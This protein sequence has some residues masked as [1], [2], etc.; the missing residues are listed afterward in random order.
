MALQD[1]SNLNALHLDVL[2]EIGNIGSGNAAS[3]LSQMLGMPINIEIPEISI[4]D[5]NEA[6]ER[7]GG[8][9]TV[10]AGLLLP[11]SVDL[12]GMI[13]FLF[14][15]DFAKTLL[16]ALMFVEINSFDEI[17]EMGFSAIHE[18]GN[19]A[20][21]AFVNAVAGM[22]GMTIDISPPSSTIDMVGAIMNVPAVYCSNISDRLL[23]MKNKFIC[24]DKH[25]DAHILLLPDIE[26]LER[27]MTKL[28]IEI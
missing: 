22:T 16:K 10:M 20:A 1:Y 18:I 27:L 12:T 9:E 3:S 23:L 21:G 5:V 11:T 26:S 24:N 6:V 14:S 4:L 25:E 15:E 17:D 19:I 2:K 7:V 13:M 8:A 28:G